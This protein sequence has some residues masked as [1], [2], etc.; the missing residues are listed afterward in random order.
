[1]EHLHPGGIP[2]PAADALLAL[3]LAQDEVV[4]RMDWANWKPLPDL[5][6]TNLDALGMTVFCSHSPVY[7][8]CWHFPVLRRGKPFS[9]ALCH[10]YILWKVSI[11]ISDWERA[12]STANPNY[13]KAELIRSKTEFMDDEP[14]GPC[15]AQRIRDSMV[16]AINKALQ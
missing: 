9:H 11:L 6:E 3:V 10:A 1:M 16:R 5:R 8:G 7:A 13:Y 12:E 2:T 14:G 4:S 15:Q